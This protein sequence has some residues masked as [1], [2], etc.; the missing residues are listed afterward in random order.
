MDYEVI[1]QIDQNP[2]YFIERKI[3]SQYTFPKLSNGFES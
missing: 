3:S 1:E 2:I